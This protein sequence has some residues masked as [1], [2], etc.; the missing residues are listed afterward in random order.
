MIKRS[1]IFKKRSSKVWI[2]SHNFKMNW[3][4][5]SAKS[6]DRQK[7]DLLVVKNTGKFLPVSVTVF[8]VMNANTG[9]PVSVS[10]WKQ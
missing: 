6:S 9:I 3:P 7:K 8:G 4:F 1:L 5:L 10:D 2:S